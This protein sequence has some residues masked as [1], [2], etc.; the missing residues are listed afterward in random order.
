MTLRQMSW[1]RAK[2]QAPHG[3]A[4]LLHT[5][6]AR[7]NDRH[8]GAAFRRI[9]AMKKARAATVALVAS[10]HDHGPAEQCLQVHLGVKRVVLRD[11]TDWTP[12]AADFNY[13]GPSASLDSDIGTSATTPPMSWRCFGQGQPLLWGGSY[14]EPA[15]F[16]VSAGM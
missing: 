8:F 13:A 7:H 11:T 14:H 2:H 15:Q 4:A 16:A 1:M 5:S 12:P 9:P 6:K 10:S 3:A